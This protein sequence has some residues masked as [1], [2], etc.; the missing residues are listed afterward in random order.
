[1]RRLFL[2]GGAMLLLSACVAPYGEPYR[3]G[4]GV[5]ETP[6]T[7]D[8]VRIVHRGPAGMPGGE[9]EDVA[10][11]RA[12]E[13]TVAAGYDWFVVDQRFTEATGGGRRNG[14]FVSIGGG[15]TD[16]G[17]AS[18]TALGGSIGFNLGD[19]GGAGRP[20][21]AS[22]LEVRMGRGVR[23]E[24]AYDARDVQSTIGARQGW[25]VYPR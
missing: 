18:V 22:T 19:L 2:L 5:Y 10:L 3:A 11:L 6:I 25:S 8:R 23:P 9:V 24:G 1:M 7:A 21:L 13:S 17:R 16:F 14:P 20:A 12:A 4:P 15:S